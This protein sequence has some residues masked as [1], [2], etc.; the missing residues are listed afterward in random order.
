MLYV[1]LFSEATGNIRRFSKTKLDKA[2]RNKII[3]IEEKK[4]KEATKQKNPE[5]TTTEDVRETENRKMLEDIITNL[6]SQ[7]T[8][9]SKCKDPDVYE[10]YQIILSEHY[11]REK[12][13]TKPNSST[14]KSKKHS[15]TLPP[16][17]A[18][19]DVKQPDTD[20]PNLAREIMKR[21]DKLQA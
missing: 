3:E 20:E 10:A 9:K 7:K 15:L 14:E 11:K 18:L 21:N 4:T 19:L 16:K 2:F 13:Q 6:I 1:F 12:K 5:E 8:K 17:T